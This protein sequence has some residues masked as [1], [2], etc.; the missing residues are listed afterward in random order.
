M[1]QL[2]D[3]AV[4]AV[5]SALA[6]SPNPAAGLRIVVQSGGC[7]GLKYMMGFVETPAPTDVVIEKNGVKIYVDSASELH[8]A[9]T[10]VDFVTA[11]EGVGFAFDNPN[12]ASKCS[13][14][15]SFG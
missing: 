15:K 6:G 14:G 13:C 11:L 8:I 9:G 12:A 1:I 10:T 3:S 2:T 4:S 7:A 5:R